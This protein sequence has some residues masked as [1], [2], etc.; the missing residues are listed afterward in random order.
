MEKKNHLIKIYLAR[1]AQCDELLKES[2]N[3]SF[4]SNHWF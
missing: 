3:D 4:N 2:L 1:R